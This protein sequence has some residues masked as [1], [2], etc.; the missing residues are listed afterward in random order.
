MA[1]RYVDLYSIYCLELN[2]FF[3]PIFLYFAQH[4]KKHENRI[5]AREMMGEK[6]A[7][8]PP[9][10]HN[11]NDN[12]SKWTAYLVCCLRFCG[13]HYFRSF[14]L[15][16]SASSGYACTTLDSKNFRGKLRNHLNRTNEYCIWWHVSAMKQKQNAW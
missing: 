13:F 16:L 1:H 2:L 8:P 14:S 15:V 4:E 9:P 12:E 5:N 7:A 11:G 10:D 6:W 3:C